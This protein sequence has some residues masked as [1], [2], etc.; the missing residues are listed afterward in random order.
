M[1]PKP[2]CRILKRGFF[3][4]KSDVK[5]GPIQASETQ[6]QGGVTTMKVTLIGASGNA[7]SRIL[8]ELQSRGHEVTA[9]V[10]NPG[11][12]QAGA[13]SRVD[14]LSSVDHTAETISGAD[15]VVSA[16]APRQAI[17]TS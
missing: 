1:R 14:D 11:K 5:S 17:R 2:G 4:K 13:K 8:H 16:Y 12:L 3:G 9:V 15:A 7:G 6:F 10:R